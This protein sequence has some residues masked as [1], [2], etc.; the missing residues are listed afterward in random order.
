MSLTSA[1]TSAP[2]DTSATN[3]VASPPAALIALGD[4]LAA[5]LVQ[6]D[7]GDFGALGGEQFGDFLADIAAGAGHD[8]HLVL[9]LHPSLFLPGIASGLGRDSIRGAAR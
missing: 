2:F 1:A 9:E 6:I 4:A 7:D 5:R 8:R 3:S